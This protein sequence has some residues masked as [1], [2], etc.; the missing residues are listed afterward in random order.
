[1]DKIK[2]W[3][4]STLLIGVAS[5]CALTQPDEQPD[6]ESVE[7]GNLSQIDSRGSEDSVDLGDTVMPIAGGG[8]ETRWLGADLV[9]SASWRFT[10]GWGW[11]LSVTPTAWA[12]ANC[13]GAQ[14]GVAA[15]AGWDE[16]YSKY[17][18]AGL[19]TNLGGMRDQ[20]ICHFQFAAFKSTWNLDEWRPDVSYADTVAALCNPG[21]PSAD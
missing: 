8:A 2:M 17:K 14:S 13:C 16:L 1:M 7:V 15:S 19:N 18:N 9:S 5:G 10:S 11:T 21:Q 6:N 20:Y 12:R 4:I 3:A